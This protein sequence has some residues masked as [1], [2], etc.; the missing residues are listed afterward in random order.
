MG[1]DISDK[2]LGFDPPKTPT[3]PAPTTPVGVQA[4]DEAD[5]I[6]RDLE[7]RLK[8]ARSRSQSNMRLPRLD[9]PLGNRPVLG[10]VL[11]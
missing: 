1:S 8:A 10:A 7:Q 11:G 6:A 3:I 5:T 2:V 9:K 4:R